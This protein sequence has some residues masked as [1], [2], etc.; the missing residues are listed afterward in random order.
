[1]TAGAWLGA[2]F[3]L[4]LPHLRELGERRRAGLPLPPVLE[5]TPSHF[6]G[7]PELLDELAREHAIVLHDVFASLAT[8]GPLDRTHLERVAELAR[9]CGALDYSEHLAMTRSP[10]GIDLGHLVAVPHTRAQL[11][12]LVDHLCAARELVGLTI[13]V[14]LPATT[15]ELPGAELS[16]GEFVSELVEQSGCGLHLDL[17]N[18]RVD[19]HNGL[20]AGPNGDADALAPEPGSLLARLDE[21]LAQAG[22]PSPRGR[23]IARRLAELPL[24]AV[25]RIHLA[26]GHLDPTGWAVDSHRAPVPDETWAL[27]AGLRG[28]VRPRAIILE[29]DDRLP[30]LAELVEQAER[31][32]ELWRAG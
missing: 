24:A 29:R 26:G 19:A 12:V 4:R 17:E 3:G 2:G 11:A 10:G 20:P 6:F 9:R 23:A 21:A 7:R 31:A 18:L 30:P 32:A 8:A 28:F 15:L 22:L 14:E 13:A 1:M 16:E 27:L 5:L 25:T